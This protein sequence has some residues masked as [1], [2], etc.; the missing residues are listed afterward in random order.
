MRGLTILHKSLIKSLYW[1][2]Y[3]KESERII[4][5]HARFVQMHVH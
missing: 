4:R 3:Q 5:I 1:Q 2:R